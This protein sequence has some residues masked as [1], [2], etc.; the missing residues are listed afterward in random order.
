MYVY[1]YVYVY[2]VVEVKDRWPCTLIVIKEVWQAKNGSFQ[3]QS[4][5]P[6]TL[7]L[8]YIKMSLAFCM[9]V[10]KTLLS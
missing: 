8:V 6:F 7:I 1:V 10:P 4:F 3:H 9:P 5:V 2:G